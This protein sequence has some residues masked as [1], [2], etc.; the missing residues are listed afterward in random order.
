[1]FWSRGLIV[2]AALAAVACGTRAEETAKSVERTMVWHE[3]GSWSGYGNRQTE[4][5]TSDTGALRVR[6]EATDAAHRSSLPASF[7]LTAHSAISGRLLQQV[8]DHVGPGS[9]LDYVGQNP[10]VFYMIIESNDVNWK[11]TVDEAIGYQ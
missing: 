5:F 7:R 4:S 2:L 11:F 8:V 10:H 1:M 3:L 6:W 9:G